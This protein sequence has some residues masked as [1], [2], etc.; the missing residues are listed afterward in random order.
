M[1]ALLSM[2]LAFCQ[3]HSNAAGVEKGVPSKNQVRSGDRVQ[4]RAVRAATTVHYSLGHP[5]AE[6]RVQNWDDDALRDAADARVHHDAV[7]LQVAED[8][9]WQDQG[10]DHGHLSAQGGVAQTFTP[11]RTG[12]PASMCTRTSRP[13]RGTAIRAATHSYK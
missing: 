7:H 4:V 10:D 13:Q 5:P 8:E 6:S 12:S 1:L 11:V 9:R 3:P 2:V